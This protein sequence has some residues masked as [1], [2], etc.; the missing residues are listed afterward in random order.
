M[1]SEEN[2]KVLDNNTNNDHPPPHHRHHYLFSKK[3]RRRRRKKTKTFEENT[4]EII[5]KINNVSS[6]DAQRMSDELDTI[7]HFVKNAE[8][9]QI[10][11][12]SEMDRKQIIELREKI[13][14]II[15]FYDV[16]VGNTEWNND[17]DDFLLPSL[18]VINRFIYFP[19]LF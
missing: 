9:V 3:Y 10:E 5:E 13:L 7:K 11:M 2:S 19:T 8:S 16:F 15:T 6:D 14:S 1:M 4:K 18:L 12:I 17:F